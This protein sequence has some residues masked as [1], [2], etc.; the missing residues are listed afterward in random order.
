MIERSKHDYRDYYEI[1][2]MIDSGGYGHVF[3]GREKK[4]KE[5]RA[6]KVMYI[7]K[8]RISLL[9]QYDR[10]EIE[11]QL[12]LC[13]EG[14]I[15]EFDFMK[16]CSK[17][18]DNSVKC[19]EYFNN[20]DNF[21]IIMELCDQNLEHLLNKKFEQDK[22]GFNP[23][24]IYEMFKE[25][26]NTL[27]IMKENN[28]IH[29]D[30]KLE[31]ILIKY[32]DKEHKKYKLKLSDYGCSK[33]LESLSRNCNTHVGTLVYMSPEILNDEEYNYKCDLWSIGIIIYRLIFGT[34]P[35]KGGTEKALLNNINRFGKKILKE[36]ENEELNDLIKKL[37]EKNPLNRIDWEM[38]FNHHFFKN[39]N[40]NEIRLIYYLEQYGVNNIFGKKFVENNKNNI[41]LIINEKKKKLI[42]K[43]LLKKG[44]NIIQIIIKNIN[45]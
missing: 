1:I 15:K 30:L 10:D 21:A 42:D 43:Y 22:K 24:E 20:N 39:K 6:I 41:E 37:L 32:E 7:E 23:K 14:F 44:E 5:F 33:R 9:S 11:E 17:N 8:I 2:N 16:I 28:I 35:Y 38:Y 4:T 18:N 45:K 29:R 34:S 36:T 25:L 19:Y 3:K 26:N 27:K 13:I 40:K 31:N 12:N